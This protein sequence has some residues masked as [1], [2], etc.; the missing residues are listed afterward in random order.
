M[1]RVFGNTNEQGALTDRTIAEDILTSQKYLSNY[2]YAPAILESMN[3]ELRSTF[4]QV[5]N[6][7]QTEAKQVFDYLNAKGWY[8]PRQADAQSVNDLKNA[9]QES[10]QIISS[11]SDETATTGGRSTVISGQNL[12]GQSTQSSQM[13]SNLQQ[14]GTSWQAQAGQQGAGWQSQP[15]SF[16][17]GTGWQPTYSQ[18]PQWTGTQ[19][20]EGQSG[21][22]PSSLAQWTRWGGQP[23]W[24]QTGTGG[25]S[26]G[27]Y[28]GF[29]TGTS[30]SQNVSGWQSQPFQVGTGWQPT[31]SQTPQ[32]TGTQTGEGQSGMGP[33]SLAQWTR[34][35]GQPSWMQGGGTGGI[36]GG[37]SG[38]QG[39]LGT[40]GIGYSG[41]FSSSALHGHNVGGWQ[42]Q[43]QSYQAGTGWQ[44][45]YSQTPQW[46]G[47]QTGEGQSGMGPS[48]LANWTR[49]GGQPSWMQGQAGN[50]QPTQW[51]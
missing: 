44:P 10:R 23:S 21:M 20:G 38:S 17:T 18:T 36:S 49:W 46:T 26:G 41:G 5:H 45:T 16:Q 14:S 29:G 11:M 30:Q 15:Q 3:P 6:D 7:T 32:W 24:M 34:W 8:K 42:S 28:G 9:A 22:G 31:Y 47:T 33:S 27:G 4:Q 43:P 51:G 1:S 50:V 48:S 40:Q 12:Y 13:P 35:G 2:Y 19:T 37:I 39:M 25:Y